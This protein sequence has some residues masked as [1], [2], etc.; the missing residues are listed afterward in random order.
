MT[1]RVPAVVEKLNT[2][3]TPMNTDVSVIIPAYNRPQSL[4]NAV[5]SVLAQTVPVS[6]VIIVDDGSGPEVGDMVGRNRQER[7]A[8]RQRVHYFYQENQ[9]QSV[10]FNRGFTEARHTW[11]AAIADDDLWLPR[12][13][14]WQLRAL[15]SFGQS[16][17][18]CFTDGWFMNNP[19]MKMTLFQ[20]VGRGYRDLLGVV[21]DAPEFMSGKHGVWMQAMLVRADLVR[22]VG[23][24]DPKL[25]YSEDHDFLFRLALVTKFCYV[26]LPLVL[27]DRAA[28]DGRH[29]GESRNWHREEFRLHMDQY[30]FEKRLRMSDGLP[31]CV[32]QAARRDLRDIHSAWA[33]WHL[34][35]GDFQKAAASVSTALAYG[36]TPN[37]ILKW[38]LM[39]TFPRLASRIMALRDQIQARRKFGIAW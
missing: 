8:W 1:F 39:R 21:A 6:E 32:R 20:L 11:L 34:H 10:A 33:N 30:R 7:A 29:G 14:E 27:V 17:G 37:L 26:N 2:H 23:G 18:L 25:R 19:N 13:L 5:E 35:N 31:P 15:E 24:V 12:K 3:K 16:Y 9:G 22:T 4:Q 36:I 38:M 28:G